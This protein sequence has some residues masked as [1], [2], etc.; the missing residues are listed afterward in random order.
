MSRSYEFTARV[1]KGLVLALCCAAL[2]AGC[3]KNKKEDRLPGERI[4]VLAFDNTLSA[5]PRLAD[6]DVILPRP[7]VNPDW[8]E[9]GGYPGHAMHHLALDGP[10]ERLWSV[11]I[12]KG[13][14]R[15]K[16]LMTNPVVGDGRVFT[17]DPNAA[18]DAFDAASGK[19]LWKWRIKSE[20]E[21]RAV[22]FGGGLAYAKGRVYATTGYGYVVAIDA[23]TGAELWRTNTGISLRGAPTVRGGRL[24]APTY[25]G[26][27]FAL[28][29]D[30]G[31]VLW[32]HVAIAES[33]G[34][35]GTASP[36]V[37]GN[38]VIAA[39]ASGE[40]SALR[41]ENGRE[42]WTDTLSRTGRTTPLA[43]ISDIDG[44]P[45][46]DD[47]RLYAI[48]H[49]GRMV[50]IDVR[51]GERV[52]ERNIGGVQ[53]PWIAGD[54]IYLVTNEGEVVCLAKRTGRVRWIKG[55]QRYEDPDDKKVIVRWS[56]PALGGDRL[57]LVASNGYAIS[58]SPYTGDIL[59]ALKISGR[60]FL[61][62]IIAGNTL[63]ILTNDGRLTAYR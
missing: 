34:M 31:K 47:G 55:L 5:D 40:L 61:P 60:A 14:S 43:S 18:V 63:Y 33:A 19:R 13:G 52:W 57:I 22:A 2:L 15:N 26:Q 11:K 62:P 23:A 51:T 21:S 59:G 10:L 28:S 1:G 56:G 30:D 53:T 49:S 46:I 44:L 3:G 42:N 36:A 7:Y 9:A 20:Q 24:F 37:T 25:D 50:A 12:G 35:L 6:V 27:L 17:I 38:T 54:F 4:S 58:L 8:P 29:T 39:F 41:V 32:Y 48:S 45:V 16:P